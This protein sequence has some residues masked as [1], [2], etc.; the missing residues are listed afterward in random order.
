MTRNFRADKIPRPRIDEERLQ[1]FVRPPLF[2]EIGAG[3]GLHAIRYAL[4]HPQHHLIAIE[5]TKE[6]YEKLHRRF[7]RHGSPANLLPMQADAI[8][9]VAHFLSE[10]SL[11]GIFLLY[12]N[13]EPK[14]PQKRWFRM[15]F[16][17]FLVKR[18]RPGGEIVLAT[19]ISAY[20]DEALEFHRQHGLKLKEDIVLPGDFPP[21]THFEKK[22]LK[23]GDICR[24]LVFTRD[25]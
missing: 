13:P 7:V 8:A 14:N 21:R 1:N 22:Y 23:R 3:Q 9:V 19:N 2:M 24:N 6:K 5:R 15:P 18:L 17:T 10:E 12:P 11:E 20:A 16:M 25:R 4:P